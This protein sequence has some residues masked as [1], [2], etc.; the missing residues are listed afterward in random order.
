AFGAFDLLKGEIEH[1]V[2]EY[3][4]RAPV[5]IQLKEPPLQAPAQNLRTNAEDIA[6]LSGQA[7][8]AGASAARPKQLPAPAGG[9]G[10]RVAAKD[11][12]RPNGTRPVAGGTSGNGNGARS[13]NGARAGNGA[14]AGGG[15]RPAAKAT[16]GGQAVRQPVAASAAASSSGS[17]SKL[18][19]ND[20]C[21]CGSGR[22]YKMCHGR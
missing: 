6:K 15:Q 3:L 17:A 1:Q 8:E 14:Q 12:S 21:Y 18:G 4:F 7:K 20:P 9:A 5:Q 16:K 22:K 10:A 13:G 19:R 11:G 2:T